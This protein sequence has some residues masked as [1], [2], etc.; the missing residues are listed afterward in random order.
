M[1]CAGGANLY[2]YCGG[3]PVKHIDPLGFTGGDP[4]DA[5]LAAELEAEAA[6]AIGDTQGAARAERALARTLGGTEEPCATPG[7][8]AGDGAGEAEGTVSA[9]AEP[10]ESHH[11]IPRAIVRL[12]RRAWGLEGKSLPELN[13]TVDLPRSVHRSFHGQ[14]GGWY[15]QWWKA[16]IK[17][18]GGYGK[19]TLE[20]LLDLAKELNDQMGL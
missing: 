13:E 14:G 12:W 16:M 10:W 5:A 6:D 7:E 8:F 19:V 1:I 18:E 3:N 20:K 11:K 9:N 4:E 17:A 2:G 15:N